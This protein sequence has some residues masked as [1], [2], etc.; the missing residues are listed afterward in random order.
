MEYYLWPGA[1]NFKKEISVL[2]KFLK[3][4]IDLILKK[5]EELDSKI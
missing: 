3:E 1:Y 4:Q 2:L 5:I